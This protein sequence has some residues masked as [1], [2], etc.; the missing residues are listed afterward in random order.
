MNCHATQIQEYQNS[1]SNSSVFHKNPNLTYNFDKSKPDGQIRIQM[2]CQTFLFVLVHVKI[3]LNIVH[4]NILY[5]FNLILKF[6]NIKDV[7]SFI[8][9][10]KTIL[11]NLL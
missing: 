10:Y 7:N 3:L 5:V 6:S 2:I 9:V 1:F 4:C 8:L 11:H